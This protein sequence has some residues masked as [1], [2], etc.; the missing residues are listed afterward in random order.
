MNYQKWWERPRAYVEPPLNPA[1]SQQIQLFSFHCSPGKGIHSS[2]FENQVYLLPFLYIFHKYLYLFSKSNS[3]VIREA[4]KFFL[5]DTLLFP[6]SL[7]CWDWITDG[8]HVGG[9]SNHSHALNIIHHVGPSTCLHPEVYTS[10]KLTKNFPRGKGVE[11][12]H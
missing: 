7:R 5:P 10:A 3:K 9:R 4:T 2:L 1:T 6:K 8:I 12:R 11:Y